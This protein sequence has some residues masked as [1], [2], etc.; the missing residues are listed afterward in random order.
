MSGART[1]EELGPWFHNLQRPAGTQTA[2]H[3]FLTDFPAYKGK[4]LAPHLPAIL[5]DWRGL[6]SGCNAGLTC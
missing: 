2:P 4:Y 5:T 1:V 6:D 3:H